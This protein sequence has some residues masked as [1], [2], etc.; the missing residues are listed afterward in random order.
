MLG[1]SWSDARAYDGTATILQPQA[2]P[3]YDGIDVHTMVA[4][5]TE[6]APPTAQDAVQ[7]TWKNQMNGDFAQTWHDAL[8]NG[9]VSNTASPKANVSLRADA[10]SQKPPAPPDHPLTIL[11]PA[12]PIPM[13]R[14]L[15]QQCVAARTAAAADETDLGQSAPGRSGESPTVE[16]TKR[17]QR[18]PIGGASGHD[19]ADLDRAGPGSR[20]ASLRFLDLAAGLRVKSATTRDTISIRSPAVTIS[21]RLKRRLAPSTWPA[22]TIT[23]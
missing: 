16:A 1:K 18:P 21:R 3:L 15:C 7:S 22:P 5:F 12:G 14:T 11:V 2:L 23:T 19:R 4:L 8:A 10:G 20:T 17:R 6:P 9:L 13:G